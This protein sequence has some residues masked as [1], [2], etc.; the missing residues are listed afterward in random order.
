MQCQFFPL[1]GQ[2]AYIMQIKKMAWSVCEGE[3]VTWGKNGALDSKYPGFWIH[4]S[5]S[6]SLQIAPC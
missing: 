6:V 2:E 3:F 1:G 5:D 4:V